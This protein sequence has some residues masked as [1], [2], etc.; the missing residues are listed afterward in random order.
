MLGLGAAAALAL[1][2]ANPHIWNRE[3]FWE[4]C[5][6]TLLRNWPL[7]WIDAYPWLR[8][9]SG[10][11]IV[12]MTAALTLVFARQLHRR[13]L[14][15]A[16]GIGAL[17][18]FTNSLVEPRYFIPAAGFVLCFLNIAAADWRRLVIWWA[19]L[20]VGHAP[21]VASALSLW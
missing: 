20:S 15:L 2:F 16:L 3:L 1:T 10:L 13:E 18:A 17:P 4:G 12:L 7:V 11:N 6:F 5:S 14:W 9:V 8:L 19:V 21:F